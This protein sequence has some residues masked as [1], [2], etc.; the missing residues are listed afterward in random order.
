MTVFAL[1]DDRRLLL[2]P[3]C[4]ALAFMLFGL[5]VGDDVW[6][7][8]FAIFSVR[9]VLITDYV[10]VGGLGAAFV[11]AG[12]VGLLGCGFYARYGGPVGGAALAALMLTLGFALFGKN[13]LNIWPI[14]AGVAL[15]GRF[16]GEKFATHLNTALFGCALAPMITE[17]LFSSLAPLWLRLPLALATGLG[18]GFVLPPVAAQLFRAHDGFSLYNIG[19][20]AGVVGALTVALYKSFGFVPE[21]VFIWTGGH[22]LLLGIFLA[23]LFLATILAGILDDP[24]A[25]ARA[26]DMQRESGQAPSDFFQKFGLGATLINIGGCGLMALLYVLA[27]RGDLNGPTIGGILTVAG[28]AGF[29]KNLR[30]IAPIFLGV[31]LGALAKSDGPA[32]PSFLLAALFG[33]T[34]APLAGRFGIV[35]GVIAGFVHSSIVH[36]VGALHGG[37]N[38]YN[39][40]FAA[41]LVAAVLG[42]IALALQAHARDGERL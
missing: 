28:F 40:G 1:P 35:T 34:L 18:V 32:E 7:G 42:P 12:L 17:I 37:L 31:A 26:L 21:P 30:N 5:A 8:I 20:T 29:G 13:L 22:N 14:L 19:F 2:L 25:L 10:G 33:S 38:L 3:L 39:N 9:D 15:Y 36:T 6:G 24:A 41:G 27:V 16:R 11:Q 23:A 4:F